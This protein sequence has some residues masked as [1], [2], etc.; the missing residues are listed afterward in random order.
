MARLESLADIHQMTPRDYRE[1]WAW[2]DLLL[3][4]PRTGSAILIDHLQQVRDT[5]RSEPLSETLAARGA[6]ASTLL[7]HLEK[8]PTQSIVQKPGA[9]PPHHEQIIRLQDRQPAPSRFAAQPPR[10]GLF[11]RLAGLLGL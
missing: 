10:V 9:A 5:G 11:R 2:V 3:G 1:S 8:A 4:D 6:D 7:A